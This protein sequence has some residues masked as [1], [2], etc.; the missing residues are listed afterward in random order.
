MDI[1][2]G[3]AVKLV[4]EKTSDHLRHDAVVDA[5]DR[6]VVDEPRHLR[7]HAAVGGVARRREPRRR[8]GP[9]VAV[10]Q[11]HVPR[12]VVPPALPSGA[13]Q[14]AVLAAPRAPGIPVVRVQANGPLQFRRSDTADTFTLVFC[15]LEGFLH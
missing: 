8:E 11:L 14:V 15:R 1:D 4:S 10:G 7:E 5:L 13:V 9:E 6:R 3:T 2:S 12:E